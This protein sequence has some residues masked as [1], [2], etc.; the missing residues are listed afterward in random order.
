MPARLKSFELNGYKTFASR[1]EFLF[2]DGITAIVGPNGS[3]KSNIADA[4]R[5][6]LGEQSYGLLR[7]KKTE[8]M[9][10]A[11]SEQR[12]RA[13]MAQ[14][15]VVFNNGDGWLPIDFSEVAITRR[16]YRDGEN[17]YLLNGQRV[18]LKDVSEL[19]A[20]S[21]LAE[22]TYT[23]IGQGLVDA[24]L[25][26]KAEDRRRLFEE[27]AG[28][29]LYRVR[30]EESLRR[31][32]STRRNLE[33]VQDILAE[34]QP[35]LR[36]LER[37]AKRA[38]EYDLI[39]ADLRTALKEFYGYHWH[40]A[41]N[42]FHE[43]H[44]A[45]RKQEDILRTA[46]QA[47]VMVDDEI[48][49]LRQKLQILH[50]ELGQGRKKLSDLYLQ[51]ESVARSRA[52]GQER[53]RSLNLQNVENETELVRRKE[54]LA[55]LEERRHLALSEVEQLS[56]E[57]AEY[58][59]QLDE[60]E[61][62]F[63][64]HQREQS[65]VEKKVKSA[66]NTLSEIMGRQ[67]HLQA[68]LDEKQIFGERQQVALEATIDNI[69]RL[70]NELETVNGTA[71]KIK[72]ELGDAIERLANYQKQ[73]QDIQDRYHKA[74][75]D[76][77]RTQKEKAEAEGQ[78]ARRQGEIEIL[79]QA[80]I[81]LS[82]YADGSQILLHT[83]GN[84]NNSGLLGVVGSHLLVPAAYELA[85]SAAL[86]E[87]V[88][89]VV[90][91]NSGMVNE[92]LDLLREKTIRGAI[93]PLDMLKPTKLLII[94][95]TKLPGE[96][97]SI[98]G[99][100]V[101]LI[102]YPNE[103][104]KVIELLLGQVIVV[105]DRRI[106]RSLL[107]S[108]NLETLPGLR[109]VTLDGELFSVN[110]MIAVGSPSA[111]ILSRPRQLLELKED[112]KNL[113]HRLVETN[114][115]FRNIEQLQHSTEELH[116][117]SLVDIENAQM[118]VREL[119]DKLHSIELTEENLQR[120]LI[121]HQDQKDN[122][123]N[124]IKLDSQQDLLLEVEL[125]QNKALSDKAQ[126]NLRVYNER[127]TALNDGDVKDRLAY[128]KTRA[129]VSEQASNDANRRYQ[130][131]IGDVERIR[132]E[133][134]EIQQRITNNS[135]E[136]G[137]VGNEQDE[138]QIMGQMI[139]QEIDSAQSQIDPLEIEVN[140]LETEQNNIL[141]K[142]TDAR[143]RFRTAEHYHTQAKINLARRQEILDS[144]RRRIEDDF[145]LVSFD[146]V[147]SV[148]GPKPLP[149]DGMVEELQFVKELLP[150]AEDAIQQQRAQLK[151]LG[152]VNLEAQSEYNE[153]SERYRFM[154]EQVTDLHKAER[155]IQEVII[156]L[157]VI[158]EREFRRTFDAVAQEFKSIFT[159]I[160]NGGMAR[161]VL[162]DPGSL[163]DTGI[164]IEARLPGRRE[165]GLSLLS[166]GERSLTA[167][168][169]VFALLRI[170]PTPFCILD[171]V[172]AM[173]DEANVGR[174]REVLTEL[175]G[176]TQFIVITHNRNTVQAAGVIYGVTMGRDSA[177]QVISLKLGE[178]GDEYGV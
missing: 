69:D 134:E 135:T 83:I 104:R 116:H 12:S 15:T 114:D 95:A 137:N 148:T 54:T 110:G 39:R 37:Q 162:T 29:G 14:A 23:I 41:Q 157:D 141:A 138:L 120:N 34:L 149:I 63:E 153:V 147:D 27:A 96:E 152:P 71:G 118:V 61:R 13:G 74:D 130:E 89:G 11:G 75:L 21:G 178:V 10:F 102:Q 22:R 92:S 16:A 90:Y 146:Y 67:A 143:Q 24:A 53:I 33:R 123:E 26:L 78:L 131:R 80:E 176:K 113:E 88:D 122:L 172:D 160:F 38:Q 168:A 56:V 105:K 17:E 119:K 139:A 106:A 62:L 84:I 1:T 159:R 103:L 46:Q 100:A 72:F 164:D 70:Q 64:Q 107:D 142:D 108:S 86:G 174:F 125:E 82:G 140:Q 87:Y 36:S 98:L 101:D 132:H 163:A 2:A 52:V 151:R 66:R 59:T 133:I 3:G 51:R 166:G 124:G 169:L 18:R 129:A 5:W 55:L 76:I 28:I 99:V 44:V 171:E 42:E 57:M 97:N 31:L 35:R 109:V 25:A 79:E 136:L 144:L 9:I 165:Q 161:L 50:F 60:A 85:I 32:D 49:L 112:L 117:S 73:H 45:A 19:L 68:R 7:G 4:L 175:S 145:G 77:K 8:D 128:W 30:R 47:Q 93:F 65:D 121:W 156:E 150:D 6:V 158:M 20:K 127:L 91:S 173:L 40:H 81:S 48:A 170:S 154:T 58:K 167:V 126:D 43:A 155:D 177:S 94:D 115:K 111:G